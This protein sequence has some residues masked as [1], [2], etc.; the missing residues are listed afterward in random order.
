MNYLSTIP[1][2]YHVPLSY[3]VREQDDP[4]HDRDFWR[5]FCLR[6]D[7][8]CAI[9]WCTFQRRLKMRPPDTQEVFGGG[10]GRAVD[11]ELRTSCGRSSRYARPTRAL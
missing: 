9:A 1:G 4:D 8:M 5:Q 2:S 11:Q 7:R 10:D 6:N 3:V